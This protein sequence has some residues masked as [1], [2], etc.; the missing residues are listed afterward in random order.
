MTN[1]IVDNAGVVFTCL[2]T[3]PNMIINANIARKSEKI[4]KKRI[5]CY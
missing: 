3:F 1:T 2:C 5:D 4:R